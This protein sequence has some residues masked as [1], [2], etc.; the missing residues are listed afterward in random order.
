MYVSMS[1]CDLRHTAV[2]EK[3][4]LSPPHIRPGY[5]RTRDV[6]RMMIRP[7]SSRARPGLATLHRHAPNIIIRK[8]F[9]S[10]PL[11]GAVSARPVLSE[12]GRA[13][14]ADADWLMPRRPL[15][16]LRRVPPT[17]LAGRTLAELVD[18]RKTWT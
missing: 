7:P 10:C 1:F 14:C 13:F 12:N 15:Q 11:A 17:S 3:L 4:R 9:A 6:I 16:V 2:G 5:E 18:G 8:N